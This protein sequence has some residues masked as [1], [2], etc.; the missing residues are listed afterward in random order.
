MQVLRK[1]VARSGVRSAINLSKPLAPQFVRFQSSIL[2]E[3]E[4]GDEARYFRDQ[5]MD[6]QK[7]VRANMERILALDDESEEK[8]ELM[9]KLGNMN[10]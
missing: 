3:K 10:S 6:R 1:V 4:K 2:V 9:T 8:K 5:E 7:T